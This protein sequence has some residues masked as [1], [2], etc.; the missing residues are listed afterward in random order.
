MVSLDIHQGPE[1][2]NKTTLYKGD[3]L[4]LT[5]QTFSVLANN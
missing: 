1:F 2:I 5:S 3:Q 4:D